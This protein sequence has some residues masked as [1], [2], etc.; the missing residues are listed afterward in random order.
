MGG[1]RRVTGNPVSGGRRRYGKPIPEAQAGPADALLK[2][3]GS[4]PDYRNIHGAR[5]PAQLR[6]VREEREGLLI[7][8]LP[9]QP[10]IRLK[11]NPFLL[12]IQNE[13]KQD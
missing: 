12:F 1:G 10:R 3:S 11:G 5:D 4:I 7:A 2:K 13:S 6:V 9:D 8:L